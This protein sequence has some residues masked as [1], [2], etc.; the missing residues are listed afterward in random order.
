MVQTF[1]IEILDTVWASFC[2]L[3]LKLTLVL[4]CLGTYLIHYSHREF[5]HS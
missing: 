3:E 5:K 4:A 1:L 2:Q